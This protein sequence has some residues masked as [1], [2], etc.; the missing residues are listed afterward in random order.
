MI[1]C[2]DSALNRVVYLCVLCWRFQRSVWI[3]GLVSSRTS[4]TLVSSNALRV[5]TLGGGFLTLGSS[6]VLGL[7]DFVSAVFFVVA[8]ENIVDSSSSAVKMLSLKGA[9]GCVGCG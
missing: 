7:A 4:Y 3:G 6:V 2:N 8:S 9:K 5:S 1:V